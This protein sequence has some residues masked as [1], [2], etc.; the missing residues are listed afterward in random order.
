MVVALAAVACGEKGADDSAGRR[1]QVRHAG[2]GEQGQAIPRSRLDAGRPERAGTRSSSTARRV[3]TTTR[4][5]SEPRG[6]MRLTLPKTAF[7]ALLVASAGIA[8]AQQGTA[9]AR[10]P[11]RRRQ[12]RQR[13]RRSGRPERRRRR[14][15][16]PPAIQGDDHDDQCCPSRSRPTATRSARAASRSTTRRSGAA[17]TTRA[18][19]RAA[20]TTCRW[21]SA[22][23]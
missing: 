16:E 21:A 1:A 17:S 12:L 5:A 3:K 14:S 10:R 9:G 22:A 11:R 13:R 6:T 8:G 19:R 15:S 20:S 2:L 7:A 18:T 4:R 23:C